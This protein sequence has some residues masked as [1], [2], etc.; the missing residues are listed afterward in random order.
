MDE[1]VATAEQI[2]D[3]LDQQM[4][5]TPQFG[6]LALGRKLLSIAQIWRIL[7]HQADQGGRFG[8]I[9]IELGYLAD[10]QVRELLAVQL[11]SRPKL[12]EVLVELGVLPEE[13]L[14][15]LLDRYHARR[16]ADSLGP[17]PEAESDEWP[18]DAVSHARLLAA[19]PAKDVAR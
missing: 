12:G 2:V 14:Q 7:N 5:R 10:E 19:R 1:G 3:A 9:A 18:I 11:E 13:Q 6:K 4:A 17:V 8:E 15:A 16:L